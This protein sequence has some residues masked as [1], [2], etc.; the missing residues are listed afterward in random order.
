VYT[1]HQPLKYL[2]A[3]TKLP[4]RQADY[5]DWLSQFDLDVKYKA[6]SLNTAADALSRKELNVLEWTVQADKKVMAQIRKG[7][8]QD[9]FFSRVLKVFAGEMPEKV[10]EKQAS[11]MRKRFR[12]D[13]DGLLYEVRRIQPRLCIPKSEMRNRVL[14]ECHDIPISGHYGGEKTAKRILESF[15]WPTAYIDAKK[16]AQTCETPSR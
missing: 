3:K 4:H 8:K 2:V 15:W 5:L 1:D 14:E 10:S 11:R 13:R 12:L 16:Y 9:S 6:G 7:Y